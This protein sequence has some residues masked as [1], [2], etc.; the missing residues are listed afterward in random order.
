MA[1]KQWP[2]S[3]QPR[4]KLLSKGRES[5]TDAELIAIF[6]RTGVQGKSAVSLAREMLNHFGSLREIFDA[7]IEQFSEIKGIGS[8]KYCQLQAALEIA[9]RYLEAKLQS[10]A[11][12]ENPQQVKDYLSH[13]LR[14]VKRE[15]FTVLFLNN[16][17][18]LIASETLFQGT[19]DG[20]AVYP[21]EIVKRA[22]N[23][24]AAAV[25]LAHNHPSGVSEPSHADI[26]I[27]KDIE[28][29]LKLVDIRLLDHFIIGDV[30]RSFAEEGLI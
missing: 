26:T 27:T 5:L 12:F 18:H 10:G 25:I 7:P 3:E 28:N 15:I 24:N 13:T 14:R 9:K 30:V 21:R 2:V 16:R 4:E 17:H 1:I 11:I 19:I 8:A 20:A 22:L 23:H 29:A 6:L